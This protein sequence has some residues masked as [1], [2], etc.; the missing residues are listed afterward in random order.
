MKIYQNSLFIENK[1]SWTPQSFPIYLELNKNRDREY[2]NKV[3]DR[4]KLPNIY[5]FPVY[6]YKPKITVLR[7]IMYNH[8]KFERID[9]VSTIRFYTDEI[10]K[11]VMFKLEFL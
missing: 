6:I 10:E 2:F 3:V 9:S 11:L 5:G 1:K 4:I 7:W 8:V